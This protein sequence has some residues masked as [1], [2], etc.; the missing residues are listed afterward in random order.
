MRTM[1][2]MKVD[3]QAGSRAIADGSI[4]QL[5]Q[6][7]CG[8][9]RPEAAYFGPEGGVRTAFLVFDWTTLPSFR[10]SPSRCAAS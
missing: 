10:A 7:T 3:T 2:K 5:I 9:L 4:T 6:E 1:L 8:R